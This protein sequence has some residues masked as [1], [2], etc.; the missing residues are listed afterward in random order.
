MKYIEQWGVKICQRD[1]AQLIPLCDL[2]VASI[3]ATIRWAI[4][5]GKPV[6]NYDVYRLR[7]NDYITA[8]GVITIEE[9]EDFIRLLN[10]FVVDNE[11]YL[12]M[13]EKQIA[14]R[15]PWGTLNGKAAESILRVID[16]LILQKKG[17]FL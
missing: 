2:Y 8:E 16:N 7:F 10:R 1:T 6:V 17:K 4:L 3:S 15:D 5:C 9:K 14:S 12:K 13:R 11:F